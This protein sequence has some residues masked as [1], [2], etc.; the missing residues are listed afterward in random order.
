MNC[1]CILEINPLSVPSFAN[2]FSHSVGCLFILLMVSF[3][4]Q[5]LLSLIR[6][7]LFNFAFLSFLLRDWSKKILLWSL[8]K[9][10][11]PRFS[12]RSFTVSVLTI[13][14]LETILTLFLGMVWGCVLTS[15]IAGG[16]PT[17]LTP[18]AEETCLFSIVYSCFPP[19]RLI[20]YRRVG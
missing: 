5:K 14:S 3:A 16:C 2:M 15:L 18:L 12:S 8:S 4:M 13:R 20:D 19:Q 7:H 17:F 11:P 6:S 1:F 9:R 10:V